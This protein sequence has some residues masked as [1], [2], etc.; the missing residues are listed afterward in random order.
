MEPPLRLAMAQQLQ[1]TSVLLHRFGPLQ[2]IEFTGMQNGA[3]LYT[4]TFQNGTTTWGIRM[5]PAGKLA[6]L[7]YRSYLGPETRGEDVEA[8][9][10]SG[11]LLK[12]EGVT[13][14]PVVLL[15]A[16]SGP[17]DRNG[18]QF[19]A[20]PGELRQLAEALAAQGIASLRF[21][22]RGIGR[23]V[24]PNLREESMNFDLMV[25]DASAWLTWLEHRTDLGPRLLAGH[26][27][28]GVV[29]IRLAQKSKVS[30]LI[31]LSTPGVRLGDSM[32]DQIGA[33]GWPPA[34]RNEALAILAKLE[35]GADVKDVSAP[36]MLLFRPSVQ[37][38]LRSELSIDPAAELR[39]ISTP[40]LVVN[41]GHDLQVAVSHAEPLLHARPDVRHFFSAE[42]SHDLKIVPADREQQQKVSFDARIPL[43]PGLVE[44]VVGFVKDTVK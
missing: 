9:G 38:F 43:A 3:D 12:P 22:K 32:R 11:T 13:R 24:D 15:I 36:L 23:S 26:S 8:A 18:N 30:G 35:S 40:T 20:G 17:T 31:L 19:G 34:L 33:A 25:G 42:M 10:M 5:S 39:I 1:A 29:A 7:F 16:G 6:A 21:D 14:P 2:K 37:P 27:E 44:A 28:G 41:G 4:V